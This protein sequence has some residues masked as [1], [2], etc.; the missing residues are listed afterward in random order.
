MGKA[1]ILDLQ[2]K[3]KRIE[4]TDY[5]YCD[6]LSYEKHGRIEEDGIVVMEN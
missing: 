2:R 6:I 4:T 3:Q 5:R 1:F